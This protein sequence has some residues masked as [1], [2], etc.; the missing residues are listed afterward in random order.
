M[1]R[2]GFAGWPQPPDDGLRGTF[3]RTYRIRGRQVPIALYFVWPGRAPPSSGR[4][5]Q[6]PEDR[7]E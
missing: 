2:T 6:P 3:H 1:I 5:P 4:A 7:E